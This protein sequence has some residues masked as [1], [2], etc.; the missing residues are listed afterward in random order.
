[1]GTV[2]DTTVFVEFERATRRLAAEHAM[3]HRCRHR[4]V[5]RLAG[6]HCQHT[7]LWPHPRSRCH[8]DNAHLNDSPTEGHLTPP[9]PNVHMLVGHLLGAQHKWRPQ[10]GGGTKPPPEREVVR[11]E[12]FRLPAPRAT[13]ADA[14]ESPNGSR[15]SVD[16]DAQALEGSVRSEPPRRPRLGPAWRSQRS[17]S[18]NLL[19]SG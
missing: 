15:S 17:A 13:S 12:I 9:T 14:N 3:Q 6:R 8:A 5:G 4:D 19:R 10:P 1:M 18:R 11:G 2:L 16:A 7:P